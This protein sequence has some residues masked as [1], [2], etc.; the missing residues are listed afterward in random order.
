MKEWFT[1][2]EL[3]GLPGMPGTE[4]GVLKAAKRENWRSRKRPKGKGREYHIQSLPETTRTHLALQCLP[5]PVAVEETR[6]AA[7]EARRRRKEQGLAQFN[8]L[9]SG[10]PKRLRAKAR[11]WVL[12]ACDAFQQQAG[13]PG[14]RGV[15]LFCQALISGEVTIPEPHRL[16]L[17]QRHGVSSL[18]AATIYRW[19]KRFDEQGLWG[20]TDGYGNRKGQ[21][22]IERHEPLK[23]LVIGAMLDQPHI[24]PAKLKQYIAIRH[25]ELD[26]A[27]VKSIERY[28]KRWQQE[29]AQIWEFLTHPDR[30]KNVRM[31]AFGSHHEHIER[32]NQLWEMD[33]TPADWMLK[34]GRHVVVG[35]IDLY[36]RRL[37]FRVSKTSKAEAVCLAFRDAVLAWG[38]PEAV[39]TDN[40]M[41]YVSERFAGLLRDLDIEQ[42]LC[43]PFAS[44]QKG[45][46][47]RHM[48]TM[49]HGI[50][51]LLPGF[52]GHNV[53]DRKR[54][55][56]RKSFAE[57]VMNPDEVIEAE[58]EAKDLQKILDDW[59]EYVYGRS[60]HQGLDGRSPWDV[61]A[62]YT[63][64]I[65]R[66]E[67]ERALDCLLMEP[68]GTRTIGKKGIR[69]EHYDYIAP[70]LAPRIGETV[71]LRLDPDDAGTLYVYSLDGEFLC[72]AKAPEL[73]GISRAEIAAAAHAE[74]KAFTKRQSRE[75]SAFKREIKENLAEVVLRHAIEQGEN[76][77]VLP[78]PAETHTTPAL[79]QAGQAARAETTAPARVVSMSDDPGERYEYWVRIG[80][81]IER[82]ER[83][84]EQ[85][86]RGW[87]AYR[88]SPDYKAM[89]RLYEDFGPGVAEAE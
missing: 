69:Y 52:I 83:V 77:T 60:P 29:N 85:E 33:S 81:R 86:R 41:E 73:T 65:R 20:L 4:R 47:E 35:V 32:L 1:A 25:P 14:R 8:A 24:T 76:V 10:H 36:S 5:Q 18:D 88:N 58:L 62:S 71:S 61:A 42:I 82:G 67:D 38:V 63:G 64:P 66:I 16:W 27:S 2:R 12:Q 70:E 54:I 80:R 40:G 55:E 84:S 39:R 68:A 46:I 23:R 34:D 48:R 19:R 9:P 21:S 72:K 45:T 87:E 15:E 11:Q 43:L 89:K 74:Q 7:L 51:D 37:K 13:M 28:M 44:E 22:I 56:A 17:P 79:E 49:S 57:R 78:K 75:Y 31:A 26:L 30:W 50:L 3:A 6:E 59:C 53:S